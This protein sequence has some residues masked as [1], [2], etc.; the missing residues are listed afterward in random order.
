MLL[1]I[2]DGIYCCVVDVTEKI[3]AEPILQHGGIDLEPAS[4]SSSFSKH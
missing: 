4:S 1:S 3:I 2:A